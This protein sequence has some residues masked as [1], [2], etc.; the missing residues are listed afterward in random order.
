MAD[1]LSI[2]A[3]VIG[4]VGAAFAVAKKLYE[5]VDEVKGAPEHL[6]LVAHKIQHSATL[7]KCIVHLIKKHESLF[8][9]C[10]EDTV[11]DLNWRFNNIQTLINECLPSDNHGKRK[12]L[13]TRIKILF[14]GHKIRDISIEL[15]GLKNIMSLVLN[16]A[17]LAEAQ[18]CLP[19]LRSSGSQQLLTTP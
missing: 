11:R 4:V 2:T 5:F 8:K 18:M 9:E 19:W 3:S 6:C 1:P 10:L 17:H 14:S 16:I 15:E 7:L 12:R 13:R